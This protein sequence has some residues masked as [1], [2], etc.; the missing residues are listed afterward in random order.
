M[1]RTL[2]RFDF[3]VAVSGLSDVGSVRSNNE[4]V[5]RVEPSLSLFLVADGMGGH[6][7]GEV[8][9]TVAAD[10]AV[11]SIRSRDAQR[12][13]EKY[14]AAPTLEA[15]RRVL[16]V[17]RRA[18]EAA[19]D[20]VLAT[21]AREPLHRGMGCTLDVV[22]L[23]GDRAFVAHAG[24]SR[25][26]LARAQ[27]TIQLTHDHGLHEAMLAQGAVSSRAPLPVQNPLVNAI[28]LSPKLTVDGMSVD[29]ARGDRIILCT[30]GI[31]GA[32]DAEA[33][34]A[35]IARAG[36]PEEAT[37][38]LVDTALVRGGRDNATA[39]VIDIGVRFVTRDREQK[40]GGL[41]ARDLAT[42]RICPLFS[43][44]PSATVLRAMAAAVEVEIAPA[45][46]LSRTIA[47]DRV[48][49]VVLEGEIISPDGRVFAD[50]TLVYPESLVG[51]W[52]SG[53]LWKATT[54]PVRVLRL[55]ADD[56]GEV[57]AGDLV[58]AAALYER[59]ARHLARIR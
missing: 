10:A 20:E 36:T 1:H 29:L 49:Y 58:L 8:A 51:E 18:A 45:D 50:G 28:G 41:L 13:F 47:G 19:N 52:R 39:I 55:R 25:V 21:A 12:A 42:V 6:A 37:R 53:S 48:A 15:R 27:A 16:A 31:H 32:I 33:E 38:S 44:L 34:L 56:F 23:L 9:A 57:C 4:D 2:P 35:Q 7:A 11:A 43:E 14:V 17:L 46:S 24:D 54:T 59:L 3:R 26:Y 22:V 5:F 30:D 40:D